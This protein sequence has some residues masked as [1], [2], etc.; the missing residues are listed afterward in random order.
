MEY[1]LTLNE[2]VPP[3]GVVSY[4]EES[5]QN[6]IVTATDKPNTYEYSMK[7][8]SE[9]AGMTHR[10]E[11]HVLP[12]GTQQVSMGKG[13]H[14]VEAAGD[15]VSFTIQKNIRPGGKTLITYRYQLDQT[16]TLLSFGPVKETIIEKQQPSTTNWF[17]DLDHERFVM[18]PEELRNALFE[19]DAPPINHHYNRIR[20]RKLAAW[21]QQNSI[22]IA[23]YG[24][25]N[26][27][28]Y[29]GLWIDPPD[30]DW[31]SITPETLIRSVSNNERYE[32]TDIN[33]GIGALSLLNHRSAEGQFIF[34]TREGTYGK[35]QVQA[36]AKESRR[37]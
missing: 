14:Q 37:N 29:G 34:R 13:R 18:P 4:T 1:L 24:D 20:S 15:Q 6:G 21:I 33:Y 23:H 10:V 17:Y 35:I 8:R 19:M 5:T 3:G 36:P 27:K 22:D 9:Y 32:K 16:A 7:Y 26:L 31:D 12:P 11:H 28:M 30:G 25:W 2:P